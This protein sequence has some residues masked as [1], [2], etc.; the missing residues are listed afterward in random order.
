MYCATCFVETKDPHHITSQGEVYSFAVV[1]RNRSGKKLPKPVV[2][3]LVKFDGIK[4][5]IVHLLDVESPKDASIGMKVSLVLKD[6]SER[7]GSLSDILGFRP[8]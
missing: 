3:A 2:V 6:R 5:G 8:T 4:G 1:D 7:V